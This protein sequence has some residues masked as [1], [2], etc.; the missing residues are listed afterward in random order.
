MT[1][2]LP[3]HVLDNLLLPDR[4]ST[5]DWVCRNVVLREGERRTPYNPVDYPY[6]RGI[7]DAADDPRITEL[8]FVAG[9]Q[10]GKSV[11][12]RAW[13]LCRLATDP[14]NS[15]FASSTEK[16]ARG[17]ARDELWPLLR[18]CR[19]TRA[20][21][22]RWQKDEA[23]DVMRLS[24]L[25]IRI[26]WSGSPTTLGDWSARWGLAG[27]YD[28]WT[29]DKSDEAD[30][31]ALFDKR[32]GA[33][34]RYQWMK[35]GTPTYEG[36]SRLWRLLL[37]G[38]NCRYQVPCPKCGGFD[39]LVLGNGKKGS[40]GIVWDRGKDGQH[41][42]L[43]ALQTARYRCGKC[44]KEWGDEYRMP[45]ARAGVWVPEGCHGVRRGSGA[46]AGLLE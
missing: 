23:T 38:S 37:G 19:T 18:E 39:V 4:V 45:A 9:T 10:V 28:K 26:G 6:H 17:T 20:W 31:G 25:A 11:S 1:L 5:W 13:F 14:A 27:E 32:F 29:R 40:A 16:L 2:R 44:G 12:A 21:C 36:T 34:S 7:H 42:P 30:P 22:P 15:I 24:S 33:Q 3:L 8:I 35:E 41:D 46:V 43:I